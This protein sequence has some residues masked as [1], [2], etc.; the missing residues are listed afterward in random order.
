MMRRAAILVL[1]AVT[2]PAGAAAFAQTPTG[3]GGNFTVPAAPGQT[4]VQVQVQGQKPNPYDCLNQQLQQQTQGAAQPT[5]SAP[6]GAN[7]P[8]NQ[9]GTFNKQGL[10][11]QYGPNLGKS[12]MPYRPPA[13][14]FSSGLHP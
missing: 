4:C 12:V 7:S 3:N 2:L 13:P 9:V 10:S 8:S 5:P 11:E 1:P 14:S 6:L